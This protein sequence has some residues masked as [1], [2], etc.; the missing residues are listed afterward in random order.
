VETPTKEQIEELARTT[1]SVA[2]ITNLFRITNRELRRLIALHW[3]ELLPRRA[4][5]GG[6]RQMLYLT[7]PIRWDTQRAP[8]QRRFGGEI[9]I[10]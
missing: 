7:G 3:P 8:K 6:L 5:L 2:Y 10:S 4:N 9:E 1:L